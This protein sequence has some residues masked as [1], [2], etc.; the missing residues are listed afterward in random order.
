M[1]AKI[2]EFIEQA[3]EM[4]IFHAQEAQKEA[5]KQIEESYEIEKPKQPEQVL[6]EE[7]KA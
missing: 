6:T 4:G 5:I 2:D 1:D 3:K 7:S